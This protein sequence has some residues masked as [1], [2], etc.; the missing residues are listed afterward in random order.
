MLRQQLAIW[1]QG[2]ELKKTVAKFS[3][4]IFSMKH[5]CSFILTAD[6]GSLTFKTSWNQFLCIYVEYLR[7]YK[8]ICIGLW[9]KKE[10]LHGKSP[11]SGKNFI[12]P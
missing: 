7:K 10:C 12:G 9:A 1:G 6:L 2:A 11:P 5:C 4:S 8:H 3:T